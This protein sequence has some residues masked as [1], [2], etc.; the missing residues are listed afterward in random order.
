MSSL[1]HW[2]TAR[3]RSDEMRRID[4]AADAHPFARFV[5]L[6]FRPKRSNR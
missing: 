1:V 2:E 3:A 6:T 4:A 5:L